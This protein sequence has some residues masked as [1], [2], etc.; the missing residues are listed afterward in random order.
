MMIFSFCCD[1]KEESN[2]AAKEEEKEAKT[3]KQEKKMFCPSCHFQHGPSLCHGNN[4]Y[5]SP[6]FK[7]SDKTDVF[8][9]SCDLNLQFS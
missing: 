3:K 4:I 6:S 1:R 9:S 8:F 7:V 2:A 5:I